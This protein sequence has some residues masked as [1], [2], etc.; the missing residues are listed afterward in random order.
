MIKGDYDSLFEKK[1]DE[2]L[3][4]VIELEMTFEEVTK[5]QKDFYELSCSQKKDYASWSIFLSIVAICFTI[6]VSFNNVKEYLEFLKMCVA[7]LI[8]L[9]ALW[10]AAHF[11]I[12]DFFNSNSRRYSQL[13]LIFMCIKPEHLVVNTA[14][15]DVKKKSRFLNFISCIYRNLNQ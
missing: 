15:A 6:V 8:I 1:K 5:A 3:A 12:N 13:S 7:F 2:I 9:A 10:N 11:I 14:K 4:M